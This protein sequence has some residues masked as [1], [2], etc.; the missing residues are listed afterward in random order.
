MLKVLKSAFYTTVQDAGRFGYRDIGVPVSGVMD[1]KALAI[2]NSLLE[3]EDDAA[4]LEITMTGPTLEFEENTYIALSGAIMNPTLNNN[5]IRNNKIYRVKQKD[6]LSYG[7]LDKG[8]R[9]YLAI[10]GGLQ[11]KKVLGSR[12]YFKAITS[13]ESVADHTEISYFPFSSFE[14]KITEMQLE[15]HFD[16]KV[17]QV[18][19]GPEYA[20]LLDR[21][22]EK[23]FG[24]EFK[25]AKDYNRMAYQLIETVAEHSI[26]MLT[27]AT[28]P[29]TVQLTPSG[30]LIILMKDGQTTGGYP[31]ILQLTDDAIALLSQKKMG[32]SISFKLI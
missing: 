22:L 2:A 21:Q 1:N 16:E 6:I 11:T 23:I 13:V 10:K 17:L 18:A 8:L 32:D 24:N 30:K 19:K 12:S 3:N 5:P 25:V 15:D 27:S 29:G 28:L 26:N 7:R 31:R 20:M 9:S 14:P 4:V